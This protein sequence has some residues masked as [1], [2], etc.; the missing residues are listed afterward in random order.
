MLDEKDGD[1]IKDIYVIKNMVDMIKSGK[2][3]VDYSV[4]NLSN[5]IMI[6]SIKVI[7]ILVVISKNIVLVIN[8]KD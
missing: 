4:I 7:V 8:V 2:Y 5:L 3:D 6:K 1:I